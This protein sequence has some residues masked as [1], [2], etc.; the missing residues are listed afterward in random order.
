MKVLIMLR[1]ESHEAG[2]DMRTI[3]GP[4]IFLAQFLGDTAPFNT[5]SGLADWAAGLGYKGLQIPTDPRLFD[6]EKAADSQTYCDD[7]KG[8]LADK[9]LEITELSTHL[10]GQLVAV[11]P[12]FDPQFDGF[13][14][15]HVRGN[16][17][18][19]QAWAVEQVKLAA[20]ASR[21]LGLTTH[22][23]LLGR[24]HGPMSIPGRSVLP[25]WWRM[26]SMSW[27]AAGSRSSMSST[28]MA[29]I[30]VSNS[31]PAKTCTMA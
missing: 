28:R 14:A 10:Q 5:L 25:V 11:H 23:S 6:L 4:G 8:M 26:P 21:R 20:V 7:I 2:R 17:A 24:W 16:P 1:E 15:P 29:S 18:A 27:P 31:T 3:K 13:A 30:S 9:G 22:A 12:A 19:R